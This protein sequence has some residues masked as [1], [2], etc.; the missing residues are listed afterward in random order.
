MSSKSRPTT[1]KYREAICAECGRE[2]YRYYTSHNPYCPD[3][4]KE[5]TLE[6]QRNKYVKHDAIVDGNR[7]KIMKQICTVI[8]DPLPY[9]EGGFKPGARLYICEIN[10]MMKMGYIQ[11]GF[12]FEQEGERR[13]I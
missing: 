2:F 10:D 4:Q 3:C 11:P 7:F 13:T 12:T 9:L 1:E 8:Y 6:R 5:I